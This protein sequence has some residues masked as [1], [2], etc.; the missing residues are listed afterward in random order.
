MARVYK[1]LGELGTIV[2]GKTPKTDVKE[3]WDGDIPFITP[4]D[5][6]GYDTYYQTETERYITALGH[7]GRRR[8]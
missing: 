3:Y 7:Q 8:Q 5:V 1:P 6:S 4:T 2:T